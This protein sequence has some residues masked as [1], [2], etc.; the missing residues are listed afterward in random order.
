MVKANSTR[1][2]PRWWRL[3]GTSIVEPGTDFLGHRQAGRHG[4][5]ECQEARTSAPMTRAPLCD[6]ALAR[7]LPTVTAPAG[8]SPRSVRPAEIRGRA[9]GVGPLRLGVEPAPAPGTVGG[10]LSPR[11]GS[12]RGSALLAG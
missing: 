10:H 12:P 1:D 8:R 9:A 4:P 2:Y 5:P 11:R 6:I 7:R 3:T